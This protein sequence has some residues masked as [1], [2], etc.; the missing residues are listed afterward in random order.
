MDGD[1][2][3]EI[4]EDMLVGSAASWDDE[5]TLVLAAASSLSFGMLQCHLLLRRNGAASVCG[6]E[7]KDTKSREASVSHPP[8]RR[9][10]EGGSEGGT[11]GSP[12]GGRHGNRAPAP[13]SQRG[14]SAVWYVRKECFF[15]SFSFLV[16]IVLYVC[17]IFYFV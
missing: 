14:L 12:E 15:V 2:R 9:E 6:P 11:E 17:L 3:W 8:R 1:D 4:A 13:T 7:G 5:A 10:S 16:F